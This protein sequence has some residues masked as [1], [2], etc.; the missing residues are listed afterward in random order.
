MKFWL[1]VSLVTGQCF[2]FR[3]H[4]GDDS[5]KSVSAKPLEFLS[6]SGYHDLV[7]SAQ[8]SRDECDEEVC[9]ECF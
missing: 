8:Q 6:L 5:R 3:F 1:A 4:A 7:I 9:S 2:I